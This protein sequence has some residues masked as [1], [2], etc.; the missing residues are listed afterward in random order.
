MKKNKTTHTEHVNDLKC[1]DFLHVGFNCYRQTSCESEKKMICNIIFHVQGCLAEDN[2][3]LCGK[4]IQRTDGEQKNTG[5]TET[6][7]KIYS[8]DTW[9]SLY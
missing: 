4:P 5:P 9:D 3:I 7:H 8:L 2:E 6:F 1:D